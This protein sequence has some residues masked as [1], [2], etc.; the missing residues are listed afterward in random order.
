[1]APAW[2]HDHTLGAT[3]LNVYA[4][5]AGAYLIDD[6]KLGLPSNFPPLSDVVPLVIQDRM[7]DT[8][9]QLFFQADSAGGFLWATNPEHPYWKPEFIGDTILVNGKAWP[10]LDV[11]PRRY[12]FLLLNGSNARSYELFVRS[13]LTLPSPRPN[14]TA[15]YVVATDGGFL[16]T[17][18]KLNAPPKGPVD[19]LLIMPG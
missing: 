19:K 3:R 4:G 15:M 11:E 13:P 5:L 16:D 1:A 7:F 9:G 17:P 12:T 8:D 2:F 10:Y 14:G 18:V 6:P